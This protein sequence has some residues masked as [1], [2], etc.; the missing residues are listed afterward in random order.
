MSKQQIKNSSS[1]LLIKLIFYALSNALSSRKFAW[2]TVELL[3]FVKV[4]IYKCF[5][6]SLESF[7]WECFVNLCRHHIKC[8]SWPL[9][10]SWPSNQL[11]GTGVWPSFDDLNF[12]LTDKSF[13]NVRRTFCCQRTKF[14]KNKKNN[15]SHR[16][17]L[18]HSCFVTLPYAENIQ[19]IANV[20][21][22]KYTYSEVFINYNCFWVTKWTW[23]WRVLQTK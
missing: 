19:Y 9:R 14:S 7:S 16:K 2:E 11:L 3:S 15:D 4:R 23:L 10:P 8:P 20:L 13:K 22:H 1:A 12:P 21:S 17:R 6:Y 18:K 5:F